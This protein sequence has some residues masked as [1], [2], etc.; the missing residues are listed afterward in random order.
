MSAKPA[1][2]NF[3]SAPVESV[4]WR[5]AQHS[6]VLNEKFHPRLGEHKAFADSNHR[7]KTIVF[8]V[9]HGNLTWPPG[10]EKFQPKKQ[11]KL[12]RYATTAKQ[13]QDF[14]KAVAA[15]HGKVFNP[16]K[17]KPDAERN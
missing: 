6:L 14:A 12:S 17:L 8:E 5:L 1:P 7:E 13:K 11:S 9:T 4:V 15:T 2:K 3:Y 16:E 10:T